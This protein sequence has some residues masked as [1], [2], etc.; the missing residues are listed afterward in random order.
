M[1][2][3]RQN[4]AFSTNR[5]L[6]VAGRVIDLNMPRIMGI[7][8]VTP[9]SFYRES[10]ASA[11]FEVLGMAEKMLGDGA[12]FLD[13]GGY[14]SRPG[15][16]EV[17]V[18]E[19]ISRVLP[20]IKGIRKRFPEAVLSV[21]TF[22]AEVARASVEAGADMVNDISGGDLDDKMAETIAALR[23]PYVI[24]HMKGN[25]Q[26]MSSLAQYEDVLLEVTLHL[27]KKSDRLRKMGV[28]D[29]VVDP[30]IGF[31]KSPE[32]NFSL[33]RELPYVR[34]L[35]LPI[36]I[37]VSRKSLIWKTLQTTPED[38]FSGT[39]VL[40]TLALIKSA[41]LLRVHDVKEAADAVRLLHYLRPN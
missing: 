34:I 16:N 3:A 15:A 19:E 27:Q 6:A 26:T 35:G 10:R 29:I 1:N 37:G 2:L 22:R 18:K 30:G 31:A 33:L 41:S 39:T 20:S 40:N 28:R 13:I 24:M 9:D 12:T 14:S 23:V 4:T 32:H 38:A 21:D 36:M 11:D 8:N 17:T 5:T 25:P 7:I